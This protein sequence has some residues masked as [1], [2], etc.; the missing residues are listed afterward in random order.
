MLHSYFTLWIFLIFWLYSFLSDYQTPLIFPSSIN[1]PR[2]HY[3]P[4][5]LLSDIHPQDCSFYLPLLS[6]HLE[7]PHLQSQQTISPPS[8]GI[9]LES[10]NMSFYTDKL[11]CTHIHFSL[12]CIFL[13]PIPVPVQRTPLPVLCILSSPISTSITYSHPQ[14]FSKRSSLNPLFS[15]STI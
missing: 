3:P 12:F 1:Q 5:Y 11:T 7:T 15:L 13:L 10:L 4:S 14:G 9:N 8:Q 2:L 6:S